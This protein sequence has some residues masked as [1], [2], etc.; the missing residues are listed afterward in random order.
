MSEDNL[1]DGPGSAE[2]VLQSLQEKFSNFL[3]ILEQNHRALR[4]I[5]ELEERLEGNRAFDVPYIRKTVEGIGEAI[6]DSLER[7]VAMGGKKYHALLER[8]ARIGAQIES[9]LAARPETGPDQF[10]IPF[11][12]LHCARAGRAGLKNCRLAEIGNRLGLRVPAGFAITA[13]ADRHFFAQPGLAEKIAAKWQDLNYSDYEALTK[14]SDEIRELVINRPVPPDL[15][16]AITHA[17]EELRSPLPADRFALRSSAVGEDGELSFAGQYATFLNVPGDQILDRYREVLA[18]KY[19]PRAIYYFMSHAL[20]ESELPMSVGCLAMIEARASGVLYTRDPMGREALVINSIFGLGPLLMEGTITPDEFR[21]SRR[22]QSPMETRVAKK[23]KRLA[24]AAAGGVREEE[25]PEPEQC[26]SSLTVAEVCELTRLGL[27]LEQ[28]FEGP[29]EVEWAIDQAGKIFILQARPLRIVEAQ[30]PSAVLRGSRLSLVSGGTTVCPGAG[31]GP[32][33]RVTAGQDLGQVPKGAVL[34]TPHPFPGLVAVMDRVAALVTEVGG[35][36]SHVATLARERRL[37]ALAGVEGAR[38]L[39]PGKVVT[40]DASAAV[41]YDGLWPELITERMSRR[42]AFADTAAYRLLK[43]VMTLVAPLNL[44]YPADP[45][46]QAE[47]CL[48]YHDLTRFIHQRAMEE[49]FAGAPEPAAA[50]QIGLELKIAIPLHMNV[51]LLDQ[52]PDRLRDRQEIPEAEISS[53][54][55][56]SFLSGV[57]QE[58]WPAPA[59]DPARQDYPGLPTVIGKGKRPG[60]SQSSFALLGREYMNLNL[61]MGYHF[62]TLEALCTAE[63][64]KN[65]IRYQYKDGGATFDRRVRRVNLI[66]AILARLGFD[67]TVKGDFLDSAVAYFDPQG[68]ARRLVLLGRLTILTKQ[69]DMVLANDAISDWYT[70]DYLRKLGLLEDN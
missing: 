18:S 8:H 25:V 16:A 14:V 42:S 27:R 62:S 4:A 26:R 64:N 53:R 9:L 67:S 17:R 34:V 59:P 3:A 43:S 51:I 41:I 37:P 63:P 20:V 22:D 40:V 33:F 60:F 70:E 46:F 1:S 39:P 58:G 65:Y 2:D 10:I 47:N 57:K 19:N 49:M 52:D 7:M 35:V 11:S 66:A 38:E 5:S 23:P 13:W 31:G 56:K 48:T 68:I 28:Y 29:Q 36:A 12:E 21:V 15:A 55:F 32:L 6:E 45:N 69:L 30:T 50:N 24:V 54:P 44:L 61:H